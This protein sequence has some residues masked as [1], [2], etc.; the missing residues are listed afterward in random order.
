MGPEHQ[1]QASI[2]VHEAAAQDSS[3]KTSFDH[4]QIE[5]LLVR[6]NRTKYSV[7]SLL[8]IVLRRWLSLPP[9]THT[10]IHKRVAVL[11]QMSLWR[12][13][14]SERPNHPGRAT[15]CRRRRRCHGSG[16]QQRRVAA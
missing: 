11:P 13:W 16:G 3:L 9:P 7:T 2:K 10:H 12:R 15:P 14:V 6:L 5:Y 1:L 4:S 8:P